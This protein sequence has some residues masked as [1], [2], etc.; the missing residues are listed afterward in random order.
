[1]ISSRIRS[2]RLIPLPLFILAA[3]AVVLGGARPA[4]KAGFAALPVATADQK[5]ALFAGGCFWSMQK[6][7]DGVPGVVSTTAGYAGGTASTP[8]YQQVQNG[9]NGHATS[10]R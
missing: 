10:V 9:R 3:G 1:M 5:V 2:A 6:A 7:F 4:P 8:S